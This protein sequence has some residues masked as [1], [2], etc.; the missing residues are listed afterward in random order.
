MSTSLVRGIRDWA[1]RPDRD[2]GHVV[3][4]QAVELPALP[5]PRSPTGSP[6]NRIINAGAAARWREARAADAELEEVDPRRL[7]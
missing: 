6:V 4:P 7:R 5:A 1:G 2:V 3:S